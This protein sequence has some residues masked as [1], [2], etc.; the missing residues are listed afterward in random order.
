MEFEEVSRLVRHA[1]APLAATSPFGLALHQQ[2]HE[3]HVNAVNVN[4]YF[5][6]FPYPA[7]IPALHK[8]RQLTAKLVESMRR[9]K[10][11]AIKSEEPLTSEEDYGMFIPF[12]YI[13][14]M[15]NMNE[16]FQALGYLQRIRVHISYHD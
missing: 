12:W 6:D 13:R 16:K 14:R 5:H 1:P 3:Q 7:L 4:S 10:K 9:L 11:S 8:K 15:A 2:Q